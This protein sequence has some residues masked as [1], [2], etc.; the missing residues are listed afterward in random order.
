MARTTD[1]IAHAL[2]KA[3]AWIDRRWP[4]APESETTDSIALQ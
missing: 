3:Q 2:T 4:L 1:D